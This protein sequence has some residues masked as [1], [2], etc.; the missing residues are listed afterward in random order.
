[1]SQ[2]ASFVQGKSP[3]QIKATL[4]SFSKEELA[5][6][7]YRWEFWAR[8]NQLPPKGPWRKWLIRAG[9]GFGKSRSAS[10]WIRNQVETNQAR[11]IAF[12]G[13]TVKD[14]REFMIEGDSGIL[15]ISHPE[16]MPTWQP[17]ICRITWP[18][19]AKAT[20]FSADEP[21]RLRGQNL[22]AAWADELA[23]WR[24]PQAWDMLMLGLRIGDNPRCVV[25]TTPKPLPHIK[26]LIADPSCVESRGSTYDNRTNLAVGFFEDIVSLYEGTRIG[27]QELHAEILDDNPGALWKRDWIEE[28]RVQQA[29]DMLKVVV[30]IDP[31]AKSNEES[32]ET[33]IVVVGFGVDGAWYIL[34]DLSLRG[35]PDEWGRAAAT[36]FYRHEADRVV[37]EVNQGGEMVEFTMATVDPRIPFDSIHASRAKR[38]RA[39]PVSAL[40]EQGRIHHVGTFPILEDQLCEWDP[41]DTRSPSPDRLDAMVH[42]VTYMMVDKQAQDERYDAVQEFRI[43]TSGMLD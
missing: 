7:K 5:A 20:T 33:G 9:R 27:R 17:S 4:K 2:V 43:D 31:A 29:P 28:G 3:A 38:V 23:S 15:A 10:E 19:G 24:R 16:F 6:L 37:A 32:D 21:E 41:M 42:G 25:S 14:V 39:E 22:D 11:R 35:T 12:V 36:A 1:M 34:D 40:S 18:N 26:K 13:P 30:S 8:P